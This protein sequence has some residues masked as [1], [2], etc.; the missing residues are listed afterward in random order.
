MILSADQA[1]ESWKGETKVSASSLGV[2][3]L[4][5][6]TAMFAALYAGGAVQAQETLSMGYFGLP[7]HVIQVEDGVPKGAAISYFNEYIAPHLGVPVNWDTEATPPTRL[8]DQLRKGEKD[9]MIFLGKTEERTRY[10]HYPD[11][12]LIIPETFLFKKEHSVSKITKVS[13][14]HDLTVGFLVGGRIP[15]QLRDDRIEYDLIA[16]KRLFER[17]VE[18]LLLGRIDAIY[19]PLSTALV[20][21]IDEM[22]VRDQVKLVPIEFLDLVQIYT[23][24]SKETV[25]E[26]IVEKYNKA[27]KTATRER[28]YLDYIDVYKSRPGAN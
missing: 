13:D 4:L 25:S 16:G 15:E 22:D 5:A 18:K 10:Y 28:R 24:F 6:A 27:L 12:Y 20:D 8:M 19:A 9:A 26:G 17:N 1:G 7:P 14:L 3:H 11:P 21:I 2:R 23:V